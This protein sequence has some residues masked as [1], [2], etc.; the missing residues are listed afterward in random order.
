MM[1]DDDYL[2]HY[3]VLGMKWGVR[4]DKR[5]PEDRAFKTRAVRKEINKTAWERARVTN[6]MGK[7]SGIAKRELKAKIAQRDQELPGFKKKVLNKQKQ[8]QKRLI[9]LAVANLVIGTY[10]A[11]HP[12]QVISA[13]KI[14]GKIVHDVA[15][16]GT[17][18][19]IQKQQKY[20]DNVKKGFEFSQKMGLSSSDVFDLPKSAY[21]VTNSLKQDNLYLED[22]LAHY[23]VHKDVLASKI[24]D[25]NQ[26]K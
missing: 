10:V 21:R 4:K 24:Y 26:S 19:T 9:K 8:Q 11:T 16:V 7:G 1:Y 15:L 25:E 14:T 17:I 6:Q 12:E 13:A 5:T 20:K 3:G 18:K 2:A 23:G 22:Y